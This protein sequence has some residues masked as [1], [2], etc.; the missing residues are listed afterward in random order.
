MTI[1]LIFWLFALGLAS[2]IKSNGM[3]IA[4]CVLVF[5]F[6]GLRFETGF[7]WPVYKNAFEIIQV[8]FSLDRILIFSQ[9][10]QVELGWLF[11]TGI[12]GQVFPEYEFLQAIVT[13]AFL[14]STFKL[15]R[16]L[17][18]RNVALAIA[19]AASFL[20]L[21]L[22]FSTIRQ[23]LALSIFNFAIVAA[24]NKRWKLMVMLS[25]A[26]VSIHISTIFYIV[27]LIYAIARPQ[28]LP[29]PSTVV[30]LVVAGIGCILA[31][32][33]VSNYLPAFAANRVILYDLAGPI[34]GITLWRIYFLF[35][36]AWIAVYALAAGP[37]GQNA[38]TNVIFHRRI[39]VA[40]AVMCMCTFSLDI[41]RDRISYEM[42]LV[43]SIYLA[44][45]GIPM[46]LVV[47]SGTVVLGLFFSIVN[48]L[49]PTNRIVFTPYQ[50]SAVVVLTGDRG[51]ARFRQDAFSQQFQ[52][53]YD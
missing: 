2:S 5:I 15:S 23:C 42:F 43:F 51:D 10:F 36:G 44:R 28:K 14:T 9:I 31:I 46:P 53:T 16:V 37:K 20:L 45:D 33:L 40:L 35:L 3:Q 48:I 12:V 8:D 21:T 41:V 49:S 29:T 18:V 47:R 1:Y 24:L 6:V 39:I 19:I 26:A 32:P 34:Q 13:I 38:T 4:F 7:D 52:R 17:G 27:A 22:M 11:I 50:N 30:L 25:I